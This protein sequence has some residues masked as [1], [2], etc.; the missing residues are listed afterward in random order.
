MPG[1]TCQASVPAGA[2]EA[3]RGRGAA[4]IRLPAAGESGP[5]GAVTPGKVEHGCPPRVQPHPAGQG[6]R[7]RPR[8][9]PGPVGVA[10]RG[11]EEDR[12][13]RIAGH[14]GSA[15][16]RGGE[17]GGRHRHATPALPTLG[18]GDEGGA[19][20]P[21]ARRRAEHEAVARR[22]EARRERL[23]LPEAA[24]ARRCRR[25]RGPGGPDDGEA[26]EEQ[27]CGENGASARKRPTIA[28][29]HGLEAPRGSAS[30]RRG[31]AAGGT[32]ASPRCTVMRR[33][34]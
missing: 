23:K 34:W 22:D 5:D 20:R 7:G 9:Q 24:R 6:R 29:R 13:D 31:E 14:G 28:W 2:R 16:G 15:R 18:G 4:G 17:G 3:E 30:A 25:R 1:S 26:E 33:G 32:G 27:G 10:A 11:G 19:G 8:P 12:A 21:R